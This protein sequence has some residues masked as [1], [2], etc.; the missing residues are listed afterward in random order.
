[1]QASWFVFSWWIKSELEIFVRAFLSRFSAVGY[2][3]WY[4]SRRLQNIIEQNI[5]WPLKIKTINFKTIMFTLFRDFFVS[6]NHLSLKCWKCFF[7]GLC[8]F[9][10]CS[11]TT[12][13][14]QV[15]ML[16]SDFF[17]K[18][19]CFGWIFTSYSE[20]KLHQTPVWTLHTHHWRTEDA[21]FICLPPP[22]WH[23]STEVTLKNISVVYNLE[24]HT[25]KTWVCMWK[26]QIFSHADCVENKFD[27]GHVWPKNWIWAHLPAVW[28]SS[29]NHWTD[30]N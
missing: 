6:F 4:P 19:H 12:F 22:H 1:M 14:L 13:T 18:D 23:K 15:L 29:M 3:Q 21:T 17:Q 10:V 26:N 24:P 30:F 20:Y 7:F 9:V 28:T 27:R 11:M 8:L 5:N 2:V 16:Y 25:E